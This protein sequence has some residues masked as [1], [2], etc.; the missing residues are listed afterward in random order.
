MDAQPTD[1]NT[2]EKIKEAA[3]KVFLEKGFA[4]TRTRDIAEESGINLALLNYYFRSKEKLFNIIMFETMQTFFKSVSHIYNNEQTDLFEKI[5][6]LVNHYIDMMMKDPNIP[7]FLLSELRSGTFKFHESIN[8]GEIM[9]KSH[10]LHQIKIHIQEK[11]LQIHP[12]DV[13]INL[14]SLIVFPFIASPV[15]K[16]IGNM[17]DEQFKQ[18]MDQRRKSVPLWMKSFLNCVTN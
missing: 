18:I 6:L 15:V 10:F 13:L 3:R 14:M 12:L 8:L 7:I 1:I 11:N 9:A 2:E 5:E 17:P 16:S 4:A